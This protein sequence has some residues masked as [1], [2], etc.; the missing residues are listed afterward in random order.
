MESSLETSIKT[1][2]N[3]L[4]VSFF[5]FWAP[6][7]VKQAEMTL[8]PKESNFLEA[9]YPKPV[10]HPVIKIVLFLNSEILKEERILKKEKKKL[11]KFKI[12]KKI[13]WNFLNRFFYL[14]EKE[15]GKNGNE[16]VN[17]HFEF[18]FCIKYLLFFLKWSFTL[19]FGIFQNFQSTFFKKS[20]IKVWITILN[21]SIS[22]SMW[23]YQT[24]YF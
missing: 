24:S 1:V 13:F 5:N 18:L 9:K 14:I 23:V 6:S 11:K 12:S 15:I 21:R 4:E 19:L 22:Y 3:L 17:P 20:K 2:T 16:N 7:S 8:N 10:S